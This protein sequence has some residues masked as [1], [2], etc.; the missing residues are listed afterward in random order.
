MDGKITLNTTIKII[1]ASYNNQAR[2]IQ[3]PDLPPEII[4]ASP[5]DIRIPVPS[6]GVVSPIS[7]GLGTPRERSGTPASG[8]RSPRPAEKI[9]QQH[10]EDVD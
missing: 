6:S 3:I 7:G 9:S 4:P 5:E 8:R 2:R 1:P 10:V